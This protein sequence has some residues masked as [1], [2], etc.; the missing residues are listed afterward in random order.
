M[1]LLLAMREG[2]PRPVFGKDENSTNNL[3]FSKMQAR[4]MWL[5]AVYY[6][7]AAKE[8]CDYPV[9][10]RKVGLNDGSLT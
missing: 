7:A 8:A 6:K 2:V 9:K 3:R 1:A 10:H 4:R 5:L